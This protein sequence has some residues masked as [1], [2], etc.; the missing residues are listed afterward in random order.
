MNLIRFAVLLL[1][2]V[3][4]TRAGTL[5]GTVRDSEGGVISNAHVV[6]HW[7]PSGS[8]Y[9]KDNIGIKQ[10]IA[11]TTDSSG[12]FSVELPPGFYDVFVTAM[13]FT[14]HCDKVRLKHKET[15]NYEVKLKM[16]PVTSKELD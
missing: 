5:S 12:H 15:R 2:S 11:A 4:Y 16:S 8:N 3:A 1:F 13:A 7:D 14:P 9:L 10:D 6:I